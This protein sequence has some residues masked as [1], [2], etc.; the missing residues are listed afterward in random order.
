[1]KANNHNREMPRCK[2]SMGSRSPMNE[3]TVAYKS[4]T[5]NIHKGC[6]DTNRKGIK[7]VKDL[8]ML[9]P[10]LSLS[11]TAPV[12]TALSEPAKSTRE[13]RLTFSPLTPDCKSVNVCVKT[14]ENTA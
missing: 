11:P 3:K 10:S 8:L 7:I 4:R 14:M 5:E 2:P 9:E 12:L 6:V 1:M 13:I